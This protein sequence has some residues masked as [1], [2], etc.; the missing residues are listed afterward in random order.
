MAFQTP[1]QKQTSSLPP[2]I[3]LLEFYL[4]PGGKGIYRPKSW[5]GCCDTIWLIDS[6]N[7]CLFGMN[8][9]PEIMLGVGIRGKTPEHVHRP[10]Q[11]YCM[12][13]MTNKELLS[14]SLVST[15]VEMRVCLGT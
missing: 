11:A 8:S 9:V 14:D 7:K 12:V 15:M 4:R 1:K 13:G 6:F 5:R 3:P 2:S 10:P